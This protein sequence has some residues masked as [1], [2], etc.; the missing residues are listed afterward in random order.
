MDLAGV[1]HL[2]HLPFGIKDFHQ[3]TTDLRYDRCAIDRGDIAQCCQ[4]FR[5]LSVNGIGRYHFDAVGS[6]SVTT[7]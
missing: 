4:I 7:G 2:D 6:H 5:N 3:L 1:R